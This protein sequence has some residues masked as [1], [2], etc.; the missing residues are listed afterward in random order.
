ML[1]YALDNAAIVRDAIL[2]H[3]RQ[4]LVKRSVARQA[5]A[6]AK[7]RT[8]LEPKDKTVLFAHRIEQ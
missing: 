1:N 5:A 7:V 4:T 8:C 2:Q 3:P 6:V